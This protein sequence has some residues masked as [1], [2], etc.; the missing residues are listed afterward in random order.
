MH[1]ALTV[2]PEIPVPPRLYGGIERIVDILARGL[3]ERGHKVA[4]LAHPASDTAGELRPYPG[5]QSWHPWDTLRNTRYVGRFL[6]NTI[7]V[8]HRSRKVGLLLII[9]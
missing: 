8:A 7:A 5:R 3:T 9:P 4:L 1:V 2:D 6:H